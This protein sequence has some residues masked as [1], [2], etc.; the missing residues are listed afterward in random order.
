MSKINR[1]NFIRNLIKAEGKTTRKWGRYS[2]SP[3]P[4]SLCL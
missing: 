4:K 2:N 1:I 3:L